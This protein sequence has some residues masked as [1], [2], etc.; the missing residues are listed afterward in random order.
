MSSNKKFYLEFACNHSLRNILKNRRWRGWEQL[1]MQQTDK[2]KFM[3]INALFLEKQNV[4]ITLKI[5]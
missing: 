3:A 5:D 2:I 4:L 1:V